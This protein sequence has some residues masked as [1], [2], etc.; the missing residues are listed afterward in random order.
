MSD[1]AGAAWSKR[2]CVDSH[3]REPGKHKHRKC[4][5]T[6]NAQPTKPVIVPPGSKRC[7]MSGADVEVYLS[8]VHDGSVSS[9]FRALYEE[10]L[11]LDVT[12]LI[13]EHH[14][15]AHKALLA[16]QSD[17]FGSCSRRT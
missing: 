6:L 1:G 13:E 2:G 5:R 9:G 3:R 12:L 16:T 11:L 4:E 7:V 10:R 17:Y 8:Q 15:Q 14:F